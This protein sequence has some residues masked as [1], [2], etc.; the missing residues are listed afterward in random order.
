MSRCRLK[1]AQQRRKR[2]ACDP[3]SAAA[4]RD[5]NPRYWAQHDHKHLRDWPRTDFVTAD[6]DELVLRGG[7]DG[8]SGAARLDYKAKRGARMLSERWPAGTRDLALT[9]AYADYAGGPVP[10]EVVRYGPVTSGRQ[11][12]GAVYVRGLPPDLVTRLEEKGAVH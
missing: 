11:R 3:W 5:A 6:G 12:S 4:S 9:V 1:P 8:G 10:V 7:G 2:S